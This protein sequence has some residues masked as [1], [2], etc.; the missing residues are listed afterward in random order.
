MDTIVM[1]MA[2]PS[3]QLQEQDV[4]LEVQITEWTSAGLIARIEVKFVL[5]NFDV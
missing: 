2:V 4:T 1:L 5:L 3:L